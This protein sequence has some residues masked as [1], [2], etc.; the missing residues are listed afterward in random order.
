LE[1]GKVSKHEF[2]YL[3]LVSKICTEK[4]E[5]LQDINK[6][7]RKHFLKAGE[8]FYAPIYSENFAKKDKNEILN[9]LQDEGKSTNR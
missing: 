8:L 9:E 1:I 2:I 4:I 5:I 7:F 6:K 3:L